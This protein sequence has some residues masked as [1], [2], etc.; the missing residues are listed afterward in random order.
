MLSRPFLA[1]PLMLAFVSPVLAGPFED[2]LEAFRQ[3]D[4]AA[5]RAAWEPLA[6]QGDASAQYNLGL[7]FETGAGLPVDIKQ[8]A[9]WFAASAAQGDSIA[10]MKMAS[11][12][13]EGRGVAQD[14]AEAARWYQR[15]AEHDE[16]SAQF[17]LGT[18]YANGRGVEKNMSLGHEMV[19]EGRQQ[20]LHHRRR[21]DRCP[22]RDK[23]VQG[24]QLIAPDSGS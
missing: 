19:S 13:A 3:G 7:L 12:Y 8:A 1:I 24:R 21:H 20:F 10:E 2:G 18:L 11:L 22:A 9:R 23:R 5:A 14:H 17:T 4:G 6:E 15:A 16:P